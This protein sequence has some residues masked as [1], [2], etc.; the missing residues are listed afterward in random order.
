[1]KRTIFL[2]GNQQLTNKNLNVI[3]PPPHLF[4]KFYFVHVVCLF[5][6]AEHLTVMFSC[7]TTIKLSFWALIS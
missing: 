1:M 4:C 2:L 5:L 7:A 6:F 3:V